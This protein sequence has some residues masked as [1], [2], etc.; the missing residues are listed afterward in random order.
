MRRS[1]KLALTATAVFFGV[2]LVGCFDVQETVSLQRDLSGKAGFSMTIN[3]EPMAEMVAEMQHTMSGKPGA[4]SPEEIADARKTILEQQKAQEDPATK[5]QEEEKQKAEMAKQLPPGVKL[6]SANFEEDGLKIKVRAEFGFDDIRKLAQIDLPNAKPGTEGGSGKNPY[7]QPF[8]GLKVVDEGSTILLTLTGA[9]PAS[10]MQPPGDQNAFDANTRKEFAAAFKDARFGI[11]ID[12]P[13]EV[14]STNATH[15]GGH[16]L[17]WE[18]KLSDAASKV[19]DT[20]MVR[21]KK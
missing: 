11:S 14:V 4:A 15:R 12:S 16:T 10:H 2:T 3:L 13:F 18:V 8:S 7:S 19:P 20:L 1:Q 21:F 17:S 9:D 6:L 5:K